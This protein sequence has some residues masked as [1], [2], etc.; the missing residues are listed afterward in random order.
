MCSGELKV[1]TVSKPSSPLALVPIGTL[2]QAE[3]CSIIA[4]VIQP[5]E[6]PQLGLVAWS[7]LASS[8]TSGQVLGGAAMPAFF[9]A[10][11]LTHITRLDELKGKDSISPFIVE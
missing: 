2:C 1:R 8:K 3:N 11:R 6:K 9:K 10:A 4:Q 7:F 5:E